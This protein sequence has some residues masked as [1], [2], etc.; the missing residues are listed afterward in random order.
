MN[1]LLVAENNLHALLNDIQP[2][3]GVVTHGT[4][5]PEHLQHP[6]ALR[7]GRGGTTAMG[8]A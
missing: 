1:D 4:D 6:E 7:G 3:I 8:G 5:T 2:L